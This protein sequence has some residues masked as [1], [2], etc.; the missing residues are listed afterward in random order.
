MKWLAAYALLV[1][2]PLAALAAILH[3][4]SRLRA[5]IEVAGEWRLDAPGYPADAR[6][7]IAQSG[8]HLSITFLGDEL[9]GRLAG[10]S[11][12]AE[13]GERRVRGRPVDVC[14]FGALLLRARVDTAAR[15]LRI[16]GTVETPDPHCPPLSFT[17][18]RA[19]RG[20]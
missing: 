19:E 4:G 2:V 15:P 8:V 10:D 16:A 17:A 18:V 20:R 1:A 12:R 11:V 9:R 6:L 5:P 7:V 3:A 14:Y 13:R